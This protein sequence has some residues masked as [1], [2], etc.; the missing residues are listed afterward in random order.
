MFLGYIGTRFCLNLL[1]AVVKKAMQNKVNL[2][3]GLKQANMI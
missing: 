2:I 3:N 1:Y